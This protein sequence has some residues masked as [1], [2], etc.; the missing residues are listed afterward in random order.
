[1]TLLGTATTD[2]RQKK[3]TTKD[4]C[5][6]VQKKR[7]SDGV[8]HEVKKKNSGIKKGRAP[9]ISHSFPYKTAKAFDVSAPFP[10]AS[11]PHKRNSDPSSS[12]SSSRV[13]PRG[14]IYTR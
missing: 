5:K 6:G 9:H 11:L 10:K 13:S 8:K 7:Y 1:M 14:G 12:S 4:Y 2:Y 3:T